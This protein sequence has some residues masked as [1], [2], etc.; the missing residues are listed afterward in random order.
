MKC[1]VKQRVIPKEEAI[2]LFDSKFW[3]TMSFVERFEFQFYT[4][5]MCMPFSVFHE[6]TEKTLGRSV[7]T[8]EF[9]FLD[10]LEKEF[11]KERKPPSFA[12]IMNLIPEEKRIMLIV[13][14]QE[15]E[16]E[17]RN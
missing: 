2:R 17:K 10:L 4:D 9:A 12:E 14:E 3:E 11:L 5:K 13:P 16:D 6:A 7:W 8:H 15:G 1:S